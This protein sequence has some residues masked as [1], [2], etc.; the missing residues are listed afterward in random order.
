M[1]SSKE[2]PKSYGVE[3]IQDYLDSLKLQEELY[4][5]IKDNPVPYRDPDSCDDF[6]SA[7]R[8]YYNALTSFLN[9]R[10]SILKDQKTFLKPADKN[11]EHAVDNKIVMEKPILML[12]SDQFGFSV[13]QMSVS[14][15]FP[16][17][18]NKYI[19]PFSSYLLLSCNEDYKYRFVSTCI[20]D[21]RT[22]GG[23]F[24]WPT[25]SVWK[26]GG[27]S[28]KKSS[29]Y[30]LNRGVKSYIEDRVDLTLLEIKNYLKYPKNKEEERW[31]EYQA[32]FRKNKCKDKSKEY[33]VLYSSLEPEDGNMRK[34]LDV[35]DSFE[36]YVDFFMLNPFVVTMG[37]EDKKEYVPINIVTSEIYEDVENADDPSEKV[38]RLQ[39]NEISSS[40]RHNIKKCEKKPQKESAKP[41]DSIA[42]IVRSEIEIIGIEEKIDTIEKMLN[43][44]RLLTLAR[45]RM[46]EAVINDGGKNIPY[47][48][49][50]EEEDGIVLQ[51]T[52]K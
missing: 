16:A 46:M 24:L 45:S 48:G 25:D 43:N 21:M 22:L 40:A 32:D 9:N 39:S 20:R 28:G 18:N 12:T 1:G 38:E 52:V 50:K 41:L 17:W 36:Q 42:S 31:K 7:G 2:Y 8:E 29:S 13:P 33:Q 10:E 35:F 6:E 49:W 15:G 26:N 30:N 44:V 37:E 51:S 11:P 5:S 47:I 19:Y 14:E 27:W 4:K 3:K 34:W 23:A